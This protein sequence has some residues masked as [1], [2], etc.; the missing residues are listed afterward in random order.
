[1]L[2]Q[3]S[4]QGLYKT[5][6]PRKGRKAR[7]QMEDLV[8]GKNPPAGNQ[9]IDLQV[10]FS[11]FQTFSPSETNQMAHWDELKKKTLAPV[12]G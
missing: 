11:P 8:Q 1:M 9:T 5:K 3:G 10:A 6:T 7:G 2:V 12:L 4:A